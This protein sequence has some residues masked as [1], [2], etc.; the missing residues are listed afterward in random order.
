M[1]KVFIIDAS[2]GEFTLKRLR[3]MGLKAQVFL[4]IKGII[5]GKGVGLA[6]D[7]KPFVKFFKF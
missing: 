6:R 4:Q 3:G 2:V 7:L 1:S 5:K